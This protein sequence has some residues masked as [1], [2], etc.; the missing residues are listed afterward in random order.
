MIYNYTAEKT[1]LTDRIIFNSKSPNNV[2][3]SKTYRD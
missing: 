2:I 1:L 3:K